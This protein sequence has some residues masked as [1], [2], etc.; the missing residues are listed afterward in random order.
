MMWGYPYDWGSAIAMVFGMLLWFGVLAVLIWALVRWLT[1]DR[2]TPDTSTSATS[3][4]EILRQRYA[5]GE[6]DEAT[7]QRMRDHLGTAG[8]REKEPTAA[9]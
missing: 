5:R 3:A 4:A 8:D 2:M 1:S 6:I 9:R 7:F